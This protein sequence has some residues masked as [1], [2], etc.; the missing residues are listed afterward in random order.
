[1][2]YTMYYGFSALKMEAAGLR[3]TGTHLPDHTV[4]QPS[5]P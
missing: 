5:R 2:G 1:M 3:N 4:L